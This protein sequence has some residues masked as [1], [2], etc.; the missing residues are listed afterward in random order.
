MSVLLHAVDRAELEARGMAL[1]RNLGGHWAAGKGMCRCPA[2]P[3]RSPSLSVRTGDIDLLFKCFAGCDTIDVLRAI[4]RLGPLPTA[5]PLNSYTAHPGADEGWLQSRAMDLWEEARAITDTPVERYLLNR[6]IRQFSPA[7][8]FH[9]RT[10]LGP[11]RQIVFRPAMLAA[12]QEGSRVIAIQRTFLDTVLARRARDLGNPRRMLG[13][14]ARGTVMLAEATDALGLAEGVETALSAMI[15]LGIPVWAALGN[16]R[17]GRVA[18]PT[19]VDRLILL[20]DN[21]RPGRRAEVLA[22]EAHTVPGRTIET[23]WPWHGLNDWNDVLR[24]EGERGGG[25]RR[26]AA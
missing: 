15:L 12:V 26:Q 18:I 3:D 2:H 24:R 9:P 7:L 8:R 13:R 6:A 4:A 11:R 10:P 20:P 14:P 22:R 1:V 16:E 23:I 21:D 17:L 25:R 19:R 5:G